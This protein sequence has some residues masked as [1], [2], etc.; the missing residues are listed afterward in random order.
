MYD[1]YGQWVPDNS[2]VDT[3][4]DTPGMMADEVDTSSMMPDDM[5]CLD[6]GPDGPGMDPGDMDT[7][8]MMPDRM[9]PLSKG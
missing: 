8:S 6:G 7:S 5:G 4:G 9:G 2:G 1:R 3:P